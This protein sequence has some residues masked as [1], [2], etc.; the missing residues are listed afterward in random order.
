MAKFRTKLHQVADMNATGIVV[1]A[2]IVEALGAGKT[3]PVNVTINGKYSYRG[4]IASMGGDYLIG[5]AK[6]HRDKAGI[7]GGDSIEVE[8][9]LDDAPREVVI[10]PELAKAL[11]KKKGAKAAFDKLSYTLRKEAVRQVETAKAQETRTRRI[12]KII[13]SLG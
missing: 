13:D 9:T 3:P 4:R 2:R 7:K 1:P 12:A 8:V 11:A 6:E 10:P 5:V